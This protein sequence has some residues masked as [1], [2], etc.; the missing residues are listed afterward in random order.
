MHAPYNFFLGPGAFGAQYVFSSNERLEINW[1][2]IKNARSRSSALGLA[3][4]YAWYECA[5]GWSNKKEK[6][7]VSWKLFILWPKALGEDP[8][9]NTQHKK[10]P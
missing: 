5:T 6:L 9:Y 7:S 10:L 1:N 3:I 2:P 4:S 8:L